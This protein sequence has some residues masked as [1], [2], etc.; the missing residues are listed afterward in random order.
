[1]SKPC[2]FLYEFSQGGVLFKMDDLD[3]ILCNRLMKN[4]DENKFAYLYEAYGKLDNHVWAKKKSNEA[5]VDEMRSITARYFVTCLSCPD[6]F[7]I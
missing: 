1:M 4:K 7:E 2:T 3:L 5:Q 6:T